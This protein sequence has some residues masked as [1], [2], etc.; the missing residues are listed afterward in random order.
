MANYE[1]NKLDK[2][3]LLSCLYILAHGFS[4]LRIKINF[5]A[6]SSAIDLAT[7]FFY[8]VTHFLCAIFYTVAVADWL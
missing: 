6:Q 7:N 1:E 5:W 4:C 2:N 8:K 3:A